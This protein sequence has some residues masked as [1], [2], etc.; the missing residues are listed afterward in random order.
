MNPE[1]YELKMWIDTAGNCP[2]ERFLDDLSEPKKSAAEAALAHI[3]ARRGV[4]VCSTEWGK[5]LGKGLYEFRIRAELDEILAEFRPDLVGKWTTAT[6]SVLLRIFFHP[7]GDKLILLLGGYDK[8]K[9]PGNRRQDAEIKQA[10]KNLIAYRLE[11]GKG[12]LKAYIDRWRKR[13][14]KGDV[15]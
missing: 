3:L 5:P 10:R 12:T 7:H 11:R 6:T 14:E 2:I 15:R 1:H 13:R 8:G 9:D 4:D